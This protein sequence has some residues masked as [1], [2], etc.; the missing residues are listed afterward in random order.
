[1]AS[2]PLPE[3]LRQRDTAPPASAEPHLVKIQLVSESGGRPAHWQKN[4][5]ENHPAGSESLTGLSRLQPDS[6]LSE[7]TGKPKNTGVG[8]LS[9]CRGTS[10]PRNG[11]QGFLHCRHKNTCMLSRFSQVQLC[12]PPGPEFPPGRRAVGQAKVKVKSLSRV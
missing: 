11:N 6:L 3:G 4:D 9:F 10:R 2:S 7:P 1:M 5:L 8:S 12:P